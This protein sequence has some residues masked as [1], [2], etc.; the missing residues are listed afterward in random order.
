MTVFEAK[1][2]FN[3]KEYFGNIYFPISECGL[4]KPRKKWTLGS[5]Q[6]SA[7]PELVLCTGGLAWATF[8]YIQGIHLDA[9][10]SSVRK[11]I[12]EGSEKK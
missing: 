1:L 10:R 6:V 8:Q 4:P 7:T 9:R 3:Y 2:L 5:L 12:K 11:S